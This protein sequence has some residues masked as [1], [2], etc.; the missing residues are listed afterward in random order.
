MRIAQSRKAWRM[1]ASAAIALVLGF[2]TPAVAA[3]SSST[4]VQANPASVA[5]GDPVTLNTQV[6]CTADPSGELG[7][8]FWDGDDIKAT[9]PVSS[10]GSASFTA[11]FNSVGTHTITAAYNGND[12]CNAS[13]DTTTVQVTQNGPTPPSG[14]GLSLFYAN[15]EGTNTINDGSSINANHNYTHN[16]NTDRTTTQNNNQR[17]DGTSQP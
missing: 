6:S 7:V 9:V 2:A 11:V 4:T 3:E 10:D 16:E 14:G 13:S 1:A 5:V 12:N 8:T 15:N 17:D